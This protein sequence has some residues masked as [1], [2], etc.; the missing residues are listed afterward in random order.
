MP[1]ANTNLQ[2]EDVR[3]NGRSLASEVSGSAR[4]AQPMRDRYPLDRQR[5]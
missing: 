1:E 4:G 2:G 5:E 3:S